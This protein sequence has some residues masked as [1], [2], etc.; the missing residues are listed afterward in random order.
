MAAWSAS[1]A[2]S[3]YFRGH[4]LIWLLLRRGCVKFPWVD[5]TVITSERKL[6]LLGAKR[7]D[8]KFYSGLSIRTKGKLDMRWE[9]T[10]TCECRVVATRDSEG[11]IRR[12]VRKRPR[13]ILGK[14]TRVKGHFDYIKAMMQSSEWRVPSKHQ[15]RRNN[16][17]KHFCKEGKV[18]EFD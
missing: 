8:I 1:A 4:D 9:E 14:M 6:L 17:S 18:R 15:R 11:K 7:C 10:T 2:L 13:K 16:F 3:K 12:G 5:S